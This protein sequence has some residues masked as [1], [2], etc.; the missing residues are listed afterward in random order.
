MSDVDERRAVFVYEAARLQA[1]AMKRRRLAVVEREEAFRRRSRRGDGD[2]G[3]RRKT[4]PAE[5]HGRLG[6]GVRGMDGP[7]PERDRGQDPPR[8]G[9]FDQIAHWSSP[10]G[11]RVIELCES[12]PVDTRRG[13]DQVSECRSCGRRSRGC[14]LQRRSSPRTEPSDGNHL[15]AT[16]PSLRRHRPRSAGEPRYCPTTQMSKGQEWRKGKPAASAEEVA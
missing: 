6:Q 7:R 4:S 2:G 1:I 8:H 15:P 10:R 11:R 13:G 14:P 12:P 3:P 16:P 5:L 9:A